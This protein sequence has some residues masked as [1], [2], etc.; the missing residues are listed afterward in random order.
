MV[1]ELNYLNEVAE[2]GY[3]HIQQ[4][5]VLDNGIFVY[6][7]CI[8][9]ISCFLK[10]I[11]NKENRFE[12]K[13]NIFDIIKLIP[14]FLMLGSLTLTYCLA[15]NI[16]DEMQLK[17]TMLYF[18]IVMFAFITIYFILVCFVLKKLLYKF[19]P[20]ILPMIKNFYESKKYIIKDKIN[21][22]KNKNI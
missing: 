13:K 18:F 5:L 8:F 4:L 22:H 6:I 11:A 9:I 10:I 14:T 1:Q 20:I 19:G 16:K 21:N 2:K 7:T 15:H 17:E 3:T 12:L